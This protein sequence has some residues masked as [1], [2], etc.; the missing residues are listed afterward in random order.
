MG[1]RN[2]LKGS[3]GHPGYSG[4]QKLRGGE[5]HMGLQKGSRDTRKDGRWDR[6]VVE[7]KGVD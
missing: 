5:R 6:Y 3:A 4:Y 1:G 2:L 7:G